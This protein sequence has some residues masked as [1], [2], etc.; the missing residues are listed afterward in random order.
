MFEIN[1]HIHTADIS[2]QQEFQ[3]NQLQL[4]LE[5]MRMSSAFYKEKWKGISFPLTD[6]DAFYRLPFTEKQELPVYSESLN[7]SGMADYCTTSGTSGTPVTVPLSF[8]DIRRL[9]E[10]E[11][12]SYQKAGIGVQDIIQLTTTLDRSFMAGLAYMEGA[13]KL[14]IPFIRTGPGM[15]EMQWERIFSLKTTVLIAVPSFILK[16]LEYAAE[17]HIDIHASRVRKIICIGESIYTEALQPNALA[18]RITESWKVELF[19]TYAS[20][21]MQTAFTECTCHQ[22]MHANPDLL[23]CEFLDE[24]NQP[25]PEGNAGE[26]VI[27]TLGVSGMPLIRFRTG[28]I[29]KPY[30]GACACG[31]NTLRVGP[32]LGRKNQLIKFKGTTLYPSA[33]QHVADS[34]PEIHDYLIL[35]K[36]DEWGADEVEFC[37]FTDGDTELLIQALR[38]RFQSA[39]RVIPA[40]TFRIAPE[41]EAIR[42]QQNSRKF[43]KIIDQRKN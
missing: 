11:A 3:W 4:L 28:D 43:L 7:T 5:R 42:Q 31:R 37:F 6:W 33:L 19:S 32:V 8:S 40:I 1:P 12:Y 26:L 34:F 27:T 23:I 39:V 22:G 15:P 13:R 38:A 25:V 10:N 36:S 29:C 18:R 24:Q 21:E 14:E 20:S 17:H 30:A 16:M 2:T 9:G 35:L 41:L